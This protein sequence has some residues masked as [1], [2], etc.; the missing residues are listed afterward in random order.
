MDKLVGTNSIG[1][2]YDDFFG[3]NVLKL[4]LDENV[5]KNNE[6]IE[7]KELTVEEIDL[8]ITELNEKIENSF[9][10]N[11]RLFKKIQSRSSKKLYSF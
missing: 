6:K 3:G 2:I 5:K 9:K 1:S 8:K 7:R 4:E 11:Y 10:E